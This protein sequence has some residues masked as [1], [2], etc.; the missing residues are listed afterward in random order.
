[1]HKLNNIISHNHN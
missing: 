1:V